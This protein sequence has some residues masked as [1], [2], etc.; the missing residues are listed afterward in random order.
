MDQGSE[1]VTVR[2]TRVGLGVFA[3]CRLEVDHLVGEIRGNTVIDPDYGSEYGVDLGDDATL[4]PCEPFRFL[5]HSC[6]PN[7]ELILSRYRRLQ[8]RRISRLWLQTTRPIA[9]GQELTID[10][11]W[12]A[13]A[14][15]PCACRSKN[16]RGW[17]VHRDQLDQ[18]LAT[19][20]EEP[21]P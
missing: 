15:I 21:T 2:A 8:G 17:I 11:A 10:Y 1:V 6:E 3:R 7:C 4:E 19:H 20:L 18:L 5:N 14:A 9:A 13:D 16:C 12:P